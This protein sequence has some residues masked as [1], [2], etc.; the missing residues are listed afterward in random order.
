ML[1]EFDDDIFLEVHEPELILED[2]WLDKLDE[3]TKLWWQ[4]LSDKSNT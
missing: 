1:Q 3:T 2:E 4:R